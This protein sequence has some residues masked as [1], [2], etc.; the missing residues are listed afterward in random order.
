MANRG[1]VS[2]AWDL[3]RVLRRGHRPPVLS[4]EDHPVFEIELAQQFYQY[5]H[6][7]QK[8]VKPFQP[9]EHGLVGGADGAVVCCTLSSMNGRLCR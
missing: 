2:I 4:R 1:D 6:A 5:L 9:C 7:L 3:V 8:L